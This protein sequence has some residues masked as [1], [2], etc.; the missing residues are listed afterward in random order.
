LRRLF[1]NP[2]IKNCRYTNEISFNGAAAGIPEEVGWQFKNIVRQR[3]NQEA[4]A[5][6][7]LEF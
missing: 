3:L 1:E 4:K 2:V 7:A 6:T 5:V